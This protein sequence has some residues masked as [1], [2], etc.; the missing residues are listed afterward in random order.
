MWTDFQYNYYQN[1]SYRYLYF[2]KIR[3]F[4]YQKLVLKTC[5][6]L[7]K[8]ILKLNVLVILPGTPGNITH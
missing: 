8:L 7:K 3:S 6:K 1:Q 5:V 2:E 4:K